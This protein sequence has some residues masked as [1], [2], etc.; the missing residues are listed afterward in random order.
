MSNYSFMSC[1]YTTVAYN[2]SINQTYLTT[3]LTDCV[4]DRLSWAVGDPFFGAVLLLGFIGVF[5]M[6]QDTRLD[7]KVAVMIPVFIIVAAISQ[8]TWLFPLTVLGIAMIL[9][10]ILLKLVNR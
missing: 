6:M 2:A 3:S 4:G 9:L 10:A 8:I 5:V 1:N 7:V